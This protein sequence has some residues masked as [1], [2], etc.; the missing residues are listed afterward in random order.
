MKKL[1]RM[2]PSAKIRFSFRKLQELKKEMKTITYKEMGDQI[3]THYRHVFR[4][5][6]L[7]Q[8]AIQVYNKRHG[9]QV[10]HLNALVVNGA[11][12]RPG[13]G[14]LTENPVDVYKFDYEP[15]LPEIDAI[16]ELII[17]IKDQLLWDYDVVTPIMELFYKDHNGI[18]KGEI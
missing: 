13:D 7:V 9:T 14:C 8:I 6:G 15:V 1:R 10:P 3:D 2:S 18:L 5:V 17:R 4:I 16:L 11:T 12:K